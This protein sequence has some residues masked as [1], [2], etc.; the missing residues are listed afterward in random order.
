[1][2]NWHIY[3]V[4]IIGILILLVLLRGNATSNPEPDKV[5]KYDDFA[6]CIADA[7]AIFY[8]AY[9]CPHCQDQKEMFEDSSKL[10]YIECSTLGGNGQTQECTDAGIT[11]YPTWR[12]SDGT[13]V[14]GV[15]NFE[16][17]AE[18]TGCIAPE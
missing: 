1:M 8:G 14:S 6:L 11:G 17:L 18:K 3:V 15:A 10:P 12:F 13:E 4:L 5:T 7:G 9:W 16:T 2:K